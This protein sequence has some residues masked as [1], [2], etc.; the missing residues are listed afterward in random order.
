MTIRE[1]RD[2]IEQYSHEDYLD[3]PVIVNHT[4]SFH[5]EELREEDIQ[6]FHGESLELNI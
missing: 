4:T 6:F 5:R 3:L 2:L 1:L